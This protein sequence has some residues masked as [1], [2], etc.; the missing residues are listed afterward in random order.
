[1]K[2]IN[3][4]T[5]RKLAQMY[6]PFLIHDSSQNR[7]ASVAMKGK[8]TALYLSMNNIPSTASCKTM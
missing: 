3:A 5:R 7:I 8:T 6:I 2:N 4:A 1:M